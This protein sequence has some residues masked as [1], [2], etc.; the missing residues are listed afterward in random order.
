VRILARAEV[1]ETLW[2]L[3]KSPYAKGKVYAR[4][5]YEGKA[6]LRKFN[7][8]SPEAYQMYYARDY[9]DAVLDLGYYDYSK[10]VGQRG[11]VTIMI[12]KGG[13]PMQLVPVQTITLQLAAK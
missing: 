4:T 10:I 2:V 13:N 1:G 5:Y 9:G 8:R 12:K 3:V 6:Q 7:A 11:D